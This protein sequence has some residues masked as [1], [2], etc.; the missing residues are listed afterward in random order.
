MLAHSP[1]LSLVIDYFF[2]SDI[3]AEDEEGAI[4]AL[5]HRDRVRRVRLQM[6]VTDLQ[7]IIV[8]MDGEYPILEF[9]VIVPLNDSSATFIFP[10]TLQAPHLRHLAL[11][12]FALP[13]ES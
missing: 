12:D 9:L 6:P 8:A 7:K 13:I 2:Q 1:P 5:K 11:R 10:D 4:L 3:T